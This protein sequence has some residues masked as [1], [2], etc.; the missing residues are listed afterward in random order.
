MVNNVHLGSLMKSSLEKEKI[1]GIIWEGGKGRE[2]SEE[3]E[4][5]T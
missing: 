2:M 4:Q 5:R 3:E 1:I